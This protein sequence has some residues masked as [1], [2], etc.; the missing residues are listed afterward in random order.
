MG[1]DRRRGVLTALPFPNMRLPHT[2]ASSMELS[3]I[4][5]HRPVDLRQRPPRPAGPLRHTSPALTRRRHTV[6]QLAIN[7]CLHHVQ[8]SRRKPRCCLS[9]YVPIFAARSLTSPLRLAYAGMHIQ[10]RSHKCGPSQQLA[11]C[12]NVHLLM[13]YRDQINR[14]EPSRSLISEGAAMITH[15]LS[16]SVPLLFTPRHR[17]V[18]RERVCCDYSTATFLFFPPYQPQ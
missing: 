6:V 2:S 9:G 1:Q 3:P 13:R 15:V 16:W 10:P 4:S 11:H 14:S 5:S 18:S 17:H 8:P 7:R 12:S